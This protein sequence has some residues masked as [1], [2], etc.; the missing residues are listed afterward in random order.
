MSESSVPAKKRKLTIPKLKADKFPDQPEIKNTAECVQKDDDVLMLSPSSSKTIQK[1][2]KP[3]VFRNTS[4]SFREPT[5]CRCGSLD[6][7]QKRFYSQ[8]REKKGTQN[9]AEGVRGIE[10]E[11][12]D[13]KLKKLY[14]LSR[15]ADDLKRSLVTQPRDVLIKTKNEKAL[16]AHSV[17]LG[18]R[19]KLKVVDGKVNLEEFSFESVEYYLSYVYTA[20]MDWTVEEQPEVRSLAESYG[21]T[22][23]ALYFSN[24]DDLE[25]ERIKSQDIDLNVAIL[26]PEASVEGEDEEKNLVLS[27]VLAEQRFILP[28]ELADKKDDISVE[29]SNKMGINYIII[30][31]SPIVPHKKRLSDSSLR[32]SESNNLRTNSPSPAKNMDANIFA[33]SP[34]VEIISCNLKKL[35]K[36]EI[37]L[38]KVRSR[39]DTS[40]DLFE[41]LTPTVSPTKNQSSSKALIEDSPPYITF[42][43]DEKSHSPEKLIPRSVPIMSQSPKKTSPLKRPPTV[44]LSPPRPCISKDDD[45]FLRNDSV[46]DSPPY[47]TAASSSTKMATPSNRGISNNL[48]ETDK[49]E[50]IQ[51][52]L[53]SGVKVLK[54][55]NV[56]PM[57]N[58]ESFTEEQLK[59]ELKKFGLRPMKKKRAIEELRKI[60]ETLHPLVDLN[61]ETPKKTV[62]ASMVAPVRLS[63]EDLEEKASGDENSQRS[64]LNDSVDEVLEESAIFG[65]EKLM[66]SPTKTSTGKLIKDVETAQKVM[67]DWLKLPENEELYNLL[68][69][70]QSNELVGS[71][72]RSSHDVR[73]ITKKILADVLDRL[74][75]TFT[76]P[77]VKWGKGKGYKNG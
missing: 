19:T 33:R 56:T 34:S 13:K 30:D 57:P 5:T 6:T 46:F 47:F 52:R 77:D 60:Y 68:L 17:I 38:D 7:I 71:M 74:H 66:E 62:T 67:L 48:T 12:M 69:S 24:P 61:S 37:I 41:T 43:H 59:G 23:L 53:G 40:V 36:P 55:T 14:R 70:M 22:D 31:E 75:I 28:Q 45:S 20:S 27:E 16:T 54:T 29:D 21:P 64:L 32:K 51:R 2:K 63:F 76:L 1:P 50:K 58:Y 9:S 65:D 3:S 44:S 4:L 15:L 73:R 42:R 18:A 10:R 35:E 11:L 26:N 25:F 72:S 49:L 39:L 8:F